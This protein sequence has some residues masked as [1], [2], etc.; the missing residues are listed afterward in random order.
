MTRPEAPEVAARRYFVTIGTAAVEVELTAGR[1]VVDGEPLTADLARIGETDAFSLLLD[2]ESQG[3]SA[4]MVGRG[5]WQVH[6]GGRAISATVQDERARMLERVSAR[7]A[8][9]PESAPLRASM[10]GLV[11]RLEVQEGDEVREGQGIVIIEAMKMENELRAA[12][13]GRVTAIYIEEGQ[14]V[15]RGQILVE[16]EATERPPSPGKESDT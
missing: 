8:P 15:D 2:G 16:F 9:T 12:A 13:P 3:L 10:P 11:V 7:S 5:V 6:M 4:R 1:A 14:A